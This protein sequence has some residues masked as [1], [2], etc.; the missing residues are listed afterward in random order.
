MLSQRPHIEE[1]SSLPPDEK[2]VESKRHADPSEVEV[3][4]RELVADPEGYLVPQNK[5]KWVR[6]LTSSQE[7]YLEEFITAN[8][9]NNP[10]EA[11][12]IV[13]KVLDGAMGE[14]F[15]HIE[16][17]VW[18]PNFKPLWCLYHGEH[19][20]EIEDEDGILIGVEHYILQAAALKVFYKILE[21]ELAD[22][23]FKPAPVETMLPT[24]ADAVFGSM[25]PALPHEIGGKIFSYISPIELY[26]SL[27]VFNKKTAMAVCLEL[28]PYIKMDI[29][30]NRNVFYTV[31]NPISFTKREDY[32]FAA[33]IRSRA[34]IPR[35][36]FALSY[37]NAVRNG[38]LKIF[39]SRYAALKYAERTRQGSEGFAF[40]NKDGWQPAVYKVV[41]S[42]NDYNEKR[43][44][45]FFTINQGTFEE[46]SA[47]V[48]FAEVSATRIIPVE[49]RL[50]ILDG[51]TKFKYGNYQ[52]RFVTPFDSDS[53]FL[54]PDWYAQQQ[55][56]RNWY[57]FYVIL[58]AI[59]LT[60]LSLL[61]TLPLWLNAKRNE[62][63][64]KLEMLEREYQNIVSKEKDLK[65]ISVGDE[66]KESKESAI[67][68]KPLAPGE[69][70][71]NSTDGIHKIIYCDKYRKDRLMFFKRCHDERI[72]ELTNTHK[73]YLSQ[74]EKQSKDLVDNLSQTYKS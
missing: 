69:Y 6:K 7:A 10:D 1:V 25:K 31:G 19:R 24:L 71:K 40:Q 56:Q 15:D 50:S 57:T 4:I 16:G 51:W 53:S 30:Q 38:K 2:Q 5:T 45:A 9:P 48:E 14:M 33:Y 36:E 63:I 52:S 37:I 60:P 61:V 27:H 17:E 29:E 70:V 35:Q 22:A 41:Y 23:E 72:T 42:G 12:K 58:S 18:F 55:S 39:K 49:A 74:S 67:S 21:P 44:E 68:K 32:P 11:R 64:Q 20:E 13:T 62:S 47:L 8:L 26:A 59:F 43:Q 65:N 28:K 66:Q 73:E 3:N 34:E 46:Q 54:Y